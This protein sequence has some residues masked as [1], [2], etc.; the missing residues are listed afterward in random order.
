MANLQD[1]ALDVCRRFPQVGVFSPKRVHNNSQAQPRRLSKGLQGASQA[2]LETELG[3]ND[4]DCASLVNALLKSGS[5]EALMRPSDQGV[6]IKL[7]DPLQA[8][9]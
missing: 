9:K 1:R 7:K 6:L 4:Q 2:N 3:I 8:A 5:V